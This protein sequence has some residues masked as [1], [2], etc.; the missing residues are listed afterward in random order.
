MKNFLLAAPLAFCLTATPLSAQ[1]SDRDSAFFLFDQGKSGEAVAIL[2]K[3]VAAGSKEPAVFER[4]GL[5]VLRLSGAYPDA[6]DRQFQRLRAR[7][8]FE[9]AVKLGSKD[10]QILSLLQSIPE[11]GGP[12]ASY[13]NNPEVDAA[14]QK[15]E[16]AYSS[17]D[18]RTALIN[19]QKALALN[20]KQYNAAVFS[21]DTYVHGATVDSAYIWYA[22][23]TE[24]DPNRETA[25]RYWSDV[26]LKRGELDEARDKAI[27]ALIAEPYN[28]IAFSGLSGWAPKARIPVGFPRVEIKSPTAGAPPSLAWAAYD[29]VRSAW[30]ESVA[31]AGSNF[32]KA[33]PGEQKYR[34]SVAEEKAAL[35]AAYNADPTNAALVNVKKLDDAGMLE[36]FVLIARADAGI[37][38]EYPAYRA[39]HREL[40]RKFWASFVVG[41]PLDK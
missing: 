37:A 19:Y 24:I 29:S 25:W 18:Y 5:S 41:T 9:V 10:I 17:G 14:M 22:R 35:L 16:V 27:E 6:K 32:A 12:D 34:H 30:R 8:A 28:R 36:S 2:D 3:L 26:L 15:A 21:G 7:L 20:P 33:Y 40:V 11:D 31:A 4:L 38:Q 39:A 13:S 23:A 1:R